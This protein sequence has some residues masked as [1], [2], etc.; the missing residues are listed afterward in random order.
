MATPSWQSST[1]Q[2]QRPPTHFLHQNSSDEP[3]CVSTFTSHTHEHDISPSLS[4]SDPFPTQLTNTNLSLLNSQQ[5]LPRPRQSPLRT[6][7]PYRNKPVRSKRKLRPVQRLRRIGRLLWKQ[8]RRSRCRQ[9][10]R[11]SLLGVFG[12]HCPLTYLLEMYVRAREMYDTCSPLWKPFL[13]G[14]YVAGLVSHGWHFT[15]ISPL[16]KKIFM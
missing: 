11:G 2:K 6:K 16:K 14:F 8:W 15:S 7:R 3:P 1:K 4:S 10:D 13:H 5:P 12:H 9:R